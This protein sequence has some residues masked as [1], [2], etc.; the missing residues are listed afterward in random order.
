MFTPKYAKYQRFEK[1]D[2]ARSIFLVFPLTFGFEQDIYRVE[3][4]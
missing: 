3:L 1:I 4:S 2:I